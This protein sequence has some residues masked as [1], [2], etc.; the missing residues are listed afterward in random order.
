MKKITVDEFKRIVDAG[1][2]AQIADVRAP[3]EYVAARLPRSQS[4]PLTHF[5]QMVPLLDRQ[6][7]VYAL[8][9]SGRRAEMFCRKLDQLGFD[10]VLVEGG[11]EAWMKKSYPVERNPGAPWS[12]ER[13]TRFGAGFFVFAAVALALL[14]DF[15]FVY[16]AGF[17]GLGLMYAGATDFCG[18][19]LV[20]EKMPWNKRIA[21]DAA[22]RS[23]R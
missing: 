2:A 6:K 9:R 17:V 3:S 22:A 13:Q 12:L 19:S 11:L 8:C 23:A 1:D 5:D 16:L 21:A 4:M 14:V 15:R 7:S 20:L 10:S 18:M